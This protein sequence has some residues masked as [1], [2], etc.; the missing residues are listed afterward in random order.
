MLD[1]MV[2]LPFATENLPPGFW[3]VIAQ[4]P[5][6]ETFGLGGTLLL[7]AERGIAVDIVFLSNDGE[8]GAREA[9]RLLGI[10]NVSFW[11]GPNRPLSAHEATIG[12]LADLIVSAKPACLF[13]PAPSEHRVAS[14]VAWEALRKTGFAAEP[15][16]YEISAQGPANR[17]LDISPVA[18]RKRDAM[19][20]YASRPAQAIAAE[21]VMGLNQSRAW[22]LPAEVSHAEAFFV[23]PKQDRP[24]D[25][26]LLDLQIRKL[27]LDAADAAAMVSVIIRTKDRPSLLPKAIASVA[28]QTHPRIELVVVNDGG[29]DVEELIREY[30][31]GSIRQVVYHA[32]RPGRGRSAA[33]NAGL[34]LATGKYLIFLDDDDW[35][36][37]EHI[38]NLVAPLDGD[39]N[40][41][42]AYG[43]TA[44]VSHMDGEWETVFEYN[45]SY[46]PIRLAYENYLPI[47]A[48]LFRKSLVDAHCRFQEDLSIYED[49]AFWF[50]LS[51]RGPF[52]HVDK[53][54]AIYRIGETCGVGV[55]G[56][57]KDFSN[58]R[59]TFIHWVKKHWTDEQAVVLAKAPLSLKR[60]DSLY[61]EAEAKLGGQQAEMNFKLEQERQLRENL[62]NLANELEAAKAALK[63]QDDWLALIYDSKSWRYTAFLRSSAKFLRALTH[64]KKKDDPA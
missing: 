57:N 48:V 26:M 22:S 63:S 29:E 49:W 58:E 41:A 64:R 55:P 10:R 1:K 28:A 59:K 37:P 2:Y 3:L 18:V 44:C 24:L 51:Q 50:L 25:A 60:V 27:W 19:A 13:F 21:R 12:R 36:L 30:A 15:W 54:G 7:A 16:S 39:A 32:L 35:F 17:L 40:L 4:C 38:A 8:E 23:W 6:D 33:A 62:A 47:H 14:A 61:R 53:P 46:D 45:D 31:T 43:N 20:A 52:K 11:G 42:A 34:D 9:A 5:Q 56:E